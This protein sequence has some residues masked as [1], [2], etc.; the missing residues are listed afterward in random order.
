MAPDEPG[1]TDSTIVE[2]I[3]PKAVSIEAMVIP[4]SLNKVFILS[5][6][7]V[8]PSKNFEIDSFICFI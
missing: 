3:K 5:P 8:S 7:L 1:I 4:C 2:I 6:N